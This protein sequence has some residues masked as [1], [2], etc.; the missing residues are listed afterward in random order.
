MIACPCGIGL[1]APTALFVGGGLAAKYGILARGGGEAFQEASSLDC[2]VFDK[3]GTLTMGGDSTVTCHKFVNGHDHTL[4]LEIVK[5]LEDNSSHP[6]AKALV[7]F[8]SRS[9][10]ALQARTIISVEEVPGKGL[11]A[12]LDVNGHAITAIIGN[13]AH[14]VDHNIPIPP[15]LV[16][17]LGSW[18]A[19]GDSVALVALLSS[20]TQNAWQLA[21]MFSIAD[22]LRPEATSVIQALKRRGIDVWMLSGDNLITANAVGAR[23]GI[24]STNIIAGVLPDE[25]A[26]K[27]EQLQQTLRNSQR[28][29]LSRLPAFLHRSSH[30]RRAAI[31]MVGDGINDAPAL[32]TAD[33]SIA[34]GSGSDIALS[35]SSFI[36]IN[37]QLTTILTLLDLS[38]VVIRRVYF[39]FGWAT[40][41]NL[42]AMPI[43]AG[44][45]YPITIGGQVD[46]HGV[47]SGEKHIKLDPVWGSLA[48]ALSSLSVICSSL[49]LRSRI[50]WFG[51]QARH[52]VKMD[53]EEAAEDNTARMV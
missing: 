2:I 18:K 16:A 17:M 28:S 43:A 26:Q 3:T 27:I 51:F 4:I 50:P 49:A 38:R 41:Y 10:E 7:E 45:L 33:V 19:R 15:H 48:M 14:L 46:G 53:G 40:V 25:K 11:K 1:A 12:T 39:N 30:T 24:P 9:Q 31:A 6:I 52:E 37:S 47:H 20:S 44:V 5:T 21:G 22:P 13:E 8:C 23:V 32:S 42:V 34:I 35:S 36:L 29:R